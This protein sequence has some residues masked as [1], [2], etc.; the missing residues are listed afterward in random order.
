[1][2]KIACNTVCEELYTIQ[3]PKY[4]FP[5]SAILEVFNR[6]D[7]LQRVYLCQCDNCR[8]DAIG[9]D[10]IDH[11]PNTFHPEQLL[12]RYA[13]VYALLITQKRAGL[14]RIFQENETYLNEGT[15]LTRD[16]L[17]FLANANVSRRESIIAPILKDQYL[18]QIRKLTRTRVAVRID[19]HEVLPIREDQERKGKGSFGEVF[20]F[21]FAYDEYRGE[22]LRDVARFARKIFMRNSDNPG[23][24][25]EWFKS[26]HANRI[27]HGHLMPALTAFWHGDKF[28]IVF[29]EAE[30]TLGAYLQTDRTLFAHEELWDQVQGLAEGLAH[31]HNVS[32]SHGD[33]KPA[34]ILIVRRVMKIA[35]FGLLQI[36]SWP[37]GTYSRPSTDAYAS[38]AASANEMDVW[39]LGAIISEIATFDLETKDG[40]QQFRDSRRADVDPQFPRLFTLSFRHERLLKRSVTQKIDALKE[41]IACGDRGQQSSGVVSPFQQHFFNPRFFVLLYGMLWENPLACPSSNDVASTLRDL[42]AQAIQSQQKRISEAPP[43][44]D[45]WGDVK[46]RTLSGSPENDNCRLEVRD[47]SRGSISLSSTGTMWPVTVQLMRGD[48]PCP[49]PSFDP[50]YTSSDSS[51]PAPK[52]T[53]HQCD[54]RW[55]TFAFE[56]MKDLLLLQTAMTQQYPFNFHTSNLQS[57]TIPNRSLSL[58]SRRRPMLDME[59]AIVQL[60]SQGSLRDDQ[61][62]WPYPITGVPLMH[63]AI[64]STEKKILLLIK[65]SSEPTFRSVSDPQPLTVILE[66]V[67]YYEVSIKKGI[68]MHIPKASKGYTRLKEARLR[69]NESQG[70][71]TLYGHS[72]GTDTDI[73][74]GAII[75]SGFGGV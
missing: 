36:S 42:R 11:R 60:W 62:L 48:E 49:L 8:N 14:I 17:R 39:S 24:P 74:S 6:D 50:V 7:A 72:L 9:P 54:G 22:G 47:T 53:L 66:N 30:Q 73:G 52:M 12:G 21:E 31:L 35:D 45:I 28:S 23:G 18:F 69:F 2:D 38:P 70:M 56:K 51:S 64:I 27:E 19:P 26:L 34:N 4:Y 75:L 3:D 55:Y 57:F 37:P 44:R 46:N 61:T 20:G 71:V 41:I 5:R 58:S 10:G 43:A 65:V 40:L 59:A 13:T 63:I 32:A 16:N 1:M 29:E 25:E 33:L 68:P 15:I 67:D